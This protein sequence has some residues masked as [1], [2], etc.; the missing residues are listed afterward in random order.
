MSTSN[1]WDTPIDHGD[2][3]TMHCLRKSI[4]ILKN[5]KDANVATQIDTEVD[6]L[7]KFYN[8]VTIV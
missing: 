8:K 3:F 1:L 5:M 2:W 6:I 4:S 7:R